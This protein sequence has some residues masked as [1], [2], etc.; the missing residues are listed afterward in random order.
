MKHV[1]IIG[2]NHK[3]QHASDLYERV[4]KTALFA[5]EKMISNACAENNIIAIGEEFSKEDLKK[6]STD[7]FVKNVSDKLGKLHKYCNPTS[8][9]EMAIGYKQCLY[10]M[11][12]ESSEEFDKRDW[13][14]EKLREI[15]WLKNIEN[16]NS[17]PMLF[18][19]GSMHVQS[20]SDLLK[21]NGIKS[22]ILFESWDDR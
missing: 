20:F 1:L 5:F 22:D 7:S 4:E 17:F 12:G 10:Q 8:E 21:K 15:I 2:A 13:E 18:V 16:L 11:G 9:E 14:N 19:C 6:D 3:Y